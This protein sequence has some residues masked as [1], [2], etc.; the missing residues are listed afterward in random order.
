MIF[1]KESVLTLKSVFF[2]LFPGTVM[3]VS[4]KVYI[5]INKTS[6]TAQSSCASFKF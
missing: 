1:C 4:L 2:V 6:P 5:I 3:E